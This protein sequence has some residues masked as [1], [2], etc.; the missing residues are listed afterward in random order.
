MATITKAQTGRASS[1]FSTG[2]Q[3]GAAIGVALLTAV[4]AVAGP[5][6]EQGGHLVANLA[7]YHDG[8]LASAA[9]A[10]LSI[11]VALTIRDT[12]AAATMVARP[13][14]GTGSPRQGERTNQ[15]TNRGDHAAADPVVRSR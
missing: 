12:D 11:P 9:V 13:R 7:A 5:T 10:L 1:I 14:R 4:L 3:F 6:R 8:F 15:E 2:K